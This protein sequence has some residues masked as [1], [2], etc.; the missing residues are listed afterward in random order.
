MSD[1]TSNC[2]SQR[3]FHNDKK[4]KEA[5][6]AK[7][8]THLKCNKM[9][10]CD[11]VWMD[12]CWSELEQCST[13]WHKKGVSF[14]SF[15]NQKVCLKNALKHWQPRVSE[16]RHCSE[17]WTMRTKTKKTTPHPLLGVADAWEEC[18][19][20]KDDR[21]PALNAWQWQMALEFEP[22]KNGNSRCVSQTF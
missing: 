11:V 14:K 16:R 15:S 7:I 1:E 6:A 4:L 9:K 8:L 5:A 10:H 17:W 19:L 20:K 12:S 13:R 18:I 2:S 21:A 22:H 3:S